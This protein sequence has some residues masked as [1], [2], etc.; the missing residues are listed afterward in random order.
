MWL[1]QETLS[2]KYGKVLSVHEGFKSVVQIS[3]NEDQTGSNKRFSFSSDG[4]LNELERVVGRVC[5]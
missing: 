5:D 1:Q 3:E 2:L 4:Q